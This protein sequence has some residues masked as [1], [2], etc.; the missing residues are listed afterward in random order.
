MIKYE[1]IDPKLRL[2]VIETCNPFYEFD[3]IKSSK[4]FHVPSKSLFTMVF[5]KTKRKI[6]ITDYMD[7]SLKVLDINGCFQEKI[8]QAG[9]LEKPWAISSNSRNDIFIT[10][11]EDMGIVKLDSSFKFIRKIGE[12]VIRNACYMA[13]DP[14]NE[15]IVYLTHYIENRVTI[16]NVLENKFINSFGIDTPEFIQIKRNRIFLTSRTEVEY[17]EGRKEF[18]RIIE[19]SNCIFVLS[20]S[21]YSLLHAIRIEDWIDPRGLHV[22]DNLNILTTAFKLDENNNRSDWRHLFVI[23]ERKSSYTSICLSGLEVLSDMLMIENKLYF[24][25]SDIIEI[26]TLK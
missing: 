24:C 23:N 10:D 9:C 19:G 3:S 17:I 16:W 14:D 7:K 2:I 13:T 26:I 12:K 5:L 18:R 22:D 21:N 6:V 8:S 20:K 11:Y 15:D 4:S 25:I 1:H